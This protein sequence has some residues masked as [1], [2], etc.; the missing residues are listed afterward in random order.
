MIAEMNRVG[1]L[2]DCSHTGYRTP[3]DIMG[4]ATQPAIFSHSNPKAL[5]SHA[6]NITDDQIRAGAKTGGVI[7]VTG[8]GYFLPDRARGLEVAVFQS[9]SGAPWGK[10][11]RN[12]RASSTTRA[13]EGLASTRAR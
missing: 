10:K 3:M 4:M 11:L 13:T 7:G 9:R 2:V 8:L 1:M 12:G 6:R 5:R